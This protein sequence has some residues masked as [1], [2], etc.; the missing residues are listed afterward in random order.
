[1]PAPSNFL[2]T[3]AS[4]RP[5]GNASRT[6]T[7]EEAVSGCLQDIQ[8][9]LIAIP[10]IAN[11]VAYKSFEYS[12]QYISSMKTAAESV[13]TAARNK[14]L[15][16]GTEAEL[17]E[18]KNAFF[19]VQSDYRTYV[20][21]ADSVLSDSLTWIFSYKAFLDSITTSTTDSAAAITILK[22]S[23]PQQITGSELTL[24]AD[25]LLKINGTALTLTFQDTPVSLYGFVN[26][27]DSVAGAEVISI[28]SDYSSATL[29]SQATKKTDNKVSFPLAQ[30]PESIFVRND[31]KIQNFLVALLES[32]IGVDRQHAD[33]AACI[34]GYSLRP[35]TSIVYTNISNPFSNTVVAGF[36]E[37]SKAC[38]KWKLRYMVNYM[39][40]N[41]VTFRNIVG[42]YPETRLRSAVADTAAFT[43]TRGRR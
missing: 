6:M 2:D 28:A 10:S 31:P 37:I 42:L 35:S 4:V 25:F 30:L 36:K 32:P 15:E 21:N 26:V 17:T 20:D 43:D 11:Y 16:V 8:S 39:L 38:E 33:V 12:E 24:P 40:S 23:V 22:A 29:A 3:L 19:A 5:T 18:A 34:R 1:M 27:G 7:E 13:F 41:G 14:E 9:I